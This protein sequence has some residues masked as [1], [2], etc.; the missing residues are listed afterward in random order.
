MIKKLTKHGNSTALVIDKPIMELLNLKDDSEVEVATDGRR[1]L[2]EPAGSKA[3]RKQ[4]GD[5]LKNEDRIHG[6][7]YRRLSRPD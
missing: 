5:W 7:V 1:I 4:L 6:E 2:I 3:S